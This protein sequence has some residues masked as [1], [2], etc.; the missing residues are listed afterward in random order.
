MANDFNL[1]YNQPGYAQR[2]QSVRSGVYA[3]NDIAESVVSAAA[4][5]AGAKLS[6][7]GGGGGGS[8]SIS[9]EEALTQLVTGTSEIVQAELGKEATL[10]ELQTEYDETVAQEAPDEAEANRYNDYVSMGLMT[11][12]DA[13]GA[14]RHIESRLPQIQA[15]MEQVK[16]FNY[17]T[18]Q[19]RLLMDTISRHGATAALNAYSKMGSSGVLKLLNEDLVEANAEANRKADEAANKQLTESPMG[20]YIPVQSGV[21]TAERAQLVQDLTEEV[22]R[23]QDVAGKIAILAKRVT[24]ENKDWYVFQRKELENQFA[25]QLTSTFTSGLPSVIGVFN[26]RTASINEIDDMSVRLG[27]WY[28]EALT[29]LSDTVM[30][31]SEASKGAKDRLDAAYGTWKDLVSGKTATT[32]TEFQVKLNNLKTE[33][34]INRFVPLSAMGVISNA[35]ANFDESSKQR[36]LEMFVKAETISKGLPTA[37]L[38]SGEWGNV[39]I[40][41]DAMENFGK[42]TTTVLGLAAHSPE[43]ADVLTENS[44]KGL[45]YAYNPMTGEVKD[46]NLL[47]GLIDLFSTDEFKTLIAPKLRNKFSTEMFKSLA[48]AATTELANAA[49]SRLDLSKKDF[50]VMAFDNNGEVKLTARGADGVYRPKAQLTNAESNAALQS[51]KALKALMNITTMDASDAAFVVAESFKRAGLA[52]TVK[53][54]NEK[55]KEDVEKAK[56]AK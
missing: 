38:G 44:V 37:L 55:T 35:V 7:G 32:A 28:N 34:T 9:N 45:Q 31:N 48:Q 1:R 26:P 43:L 49:A 46:P 12:E 13:E 19:H 42:F 40:P 56:K 4:T 27:E 16:N 53:G 54:L 29:R 20:K 50:Y 36:V 39:I 51:T 23:T 21:T 6:D 47:V 30:Y 2:P 52:I 24:P 15:K 11:E 25:T 33:Q 10:R 18:A 41:R 3:W 22:N 5:F 17:K 8:D 14:M